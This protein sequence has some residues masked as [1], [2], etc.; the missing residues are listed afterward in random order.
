MLSISTKLEKLS[1]ISTA[2][3]VLFQSISTVFLFLTMKIIPV[4]CAVIFHQGKVLAA[5]RSE[6]MDLPGKWEFPGGKIEEEESPEACLVREIKEELGV[7]IKIVSTLPPNEH[8]Y[9]SGKI[10]RLIPF[11]A[12]LKTFD[13]RLLEHAEISWLGEKELFAVD[14]AAADL[15]VMHYLHDNWVKMIAEIKPIQ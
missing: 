12:T 6:S 15:P 10:I 9:S 8:S 14:W 2:L 13:F 4:T 1:P 7:Q 3:A 5:K 11:T